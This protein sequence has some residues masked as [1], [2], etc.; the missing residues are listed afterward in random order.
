MRQRLIVI[1]DFI[2]TYL[3]FFLFCYVIVDTIFF[4]S[5]YPFSLFVLLFHI[6][7]LFALGYQF[8]YN[9]KRHPIDRIFNDWKY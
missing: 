5:F 2:V 4:L 3:C 7:A 1:G 6:L 9:R 8:L